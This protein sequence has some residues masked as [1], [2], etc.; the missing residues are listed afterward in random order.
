MYYAIVG[1]VFSFRSLSRYVS[2]LVEGLLRRENKSFP[3]YESSSL[4]TGG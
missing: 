3:D 2:D 4:G 1:F